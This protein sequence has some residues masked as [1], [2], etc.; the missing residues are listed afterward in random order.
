LLGFLKE[1]SEGEALGIKSLFSKQTREENVVG[2]KILVASLDPRFAELQKIDS[3]S[4]SRFYRTPTIAVF[5]GAQEL[6]ETIGMGYDI[7]HLFCDVSENGTI[8]GSNGTTSTGA[9][10]IQS[11]CDSDVKLLWVASENKPDGYIK[12]FRADGKRLNLVMTMSRNGSKFSTFLEKILS[13]MSAGETMPV[14]WVAV[15]PQSPQDPRHQ[16]SPA[17]I[18]A[19]GRGGVKLR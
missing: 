8:I 18:F 3:T 4:Y 17:C 10:L 7:V 14:A 9:S 16:E 5:A 11:C 12:G 6:L 19:A 13:K 1:P 2:T 15:A